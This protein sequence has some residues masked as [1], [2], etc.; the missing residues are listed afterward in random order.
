MIH[1]SFIQVL[2]VP[3]ITYI[4]WKNSNHYSN[5]LVT[6]LYAQY[7]NSYKATAS[8]VPQNRVASQTLPQYKRPGEQIINDDWP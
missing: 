1:I 2:Q 3:T 7:V 6:H 8:I 4:N 5:W